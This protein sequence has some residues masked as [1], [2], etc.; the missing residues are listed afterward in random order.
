LDVAD[1]VIAELKMLGAVTV[2]RVSYHLLP[3]TKVRGVEGPLKVNETGKGTD[4]V[5]IERTSVMEQAARPKATI[6]KQVNEKNSQFLRRHTSAEAIVF[7][8]RVRRTITDTTLEVRE[9]PTCES[10]ETTCRST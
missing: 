1:V 8:T 6:K 4:A 10:C 9:Y 3:P 2:R 7:T 5:R